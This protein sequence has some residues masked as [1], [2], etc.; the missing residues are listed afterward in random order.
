MGWAHCGPN[1]HGQQTGYGVSAVCDEPG[2]DEQIDRGLGYLCGDNYILGALHDH[3][4]TCA[5]YYCEKHL[6]YVD[7]ENRGVRVCARCRD[8]IE[9]REENDESVSRSDEEDSGD[10]RAE[11]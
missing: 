7:V 11:T 9:K 10:G 1:R 2:C 6:F 3:D 5:K 4:F 8:E